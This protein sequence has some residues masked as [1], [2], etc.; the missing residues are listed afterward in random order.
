MAVNLLSSLL[1]GFAG[2]ANGT[3]GIYVRGSSMRA[4]WYDDLEASSSNSSG[5][6]IVLDAYGS[7]LVYVNQL[8]DVV[9]KDANGNPVRSYGD[10]HSAP[11]VEVISPAFTGID[12]VTAASAVNKPTTLQAALDKWE[13]NA[14]GPDWKVD[15]GGVDTT[16]LNA[17]GA[18]S[19]LLFNVKSP[20]Y[21]A[22]G[23]GI[24]NDQTAIA[25]ALA[26]AVA[27]GGGIVFFPKG[28]YLI[29]TAIEWD[30]RVSILGIGA[31]LSVITTNSP[32]NARI[33]TWTSG[34][35]QASPQSIIGMS[36]AASQSNTGEQ[37]YCN[38]AVHL[39]VERCIFGASTSAT[40]ILANMAGSNSRICFRDCQFK[41]NSATN[42]A[43]TWATTAN[44][45]VSNCRF[46]TTGASFAGAMIR[47]SGAS[48]T[49]DG[50][51]F[52]I[53]S[54]TN[55]A[56]MY[57]VELLNAAGRVSVTNCKFIPLGQTF[58]CCIKLLG[59]AMVTTSGNDYSFS[60][61]HEAIGS[62]L[63]DGSRLQFSNDSSAS[64]STTIPDYRSLYVYTTAGASPVFAMPT[65]YCSG[66]VL[67][68]LVS[69]TSAGAWTP[70][71]SGVTL[72]GNTNISNIAAGSFAYQVFQLFGTTWRAIG[73]N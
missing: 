37:L 60:I 23:D 9:I 10:G 40:G 19:G 26:A 53:S 64:G 44:V 71:Y 28:T 69:N 32:S 73:P 45:T 48:D 63:A 39:V 41:I 13:T 67:T 3:A 14:G 58:T 30:H 27:A 42:H 56:T 46:L 7:A 29:T 11:S 47:P 25:A 49:I 15:I 17:L 50:C 43:A 31:G 6:D 51:F 22:V 20:A 5:A 8:V 18:L 34:T 21:G 52:D 33:L 36:F 55:V 12:Y 65:K 62:L 35:S 61:W 24:T 68:T 66:Q 59:G 38:V 54:V 70:T 4:T 1:S 72:G 16:M 57:G 2:A